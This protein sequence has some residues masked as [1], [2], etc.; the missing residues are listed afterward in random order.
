MAEASELV[1][2]LGITSDSIVSMSALVGVDEDGS[3]QRAITARA[4]HARDGTIEP[5]ANII[6]MRCGHVLE[7]SALKRLKNSMRPDAVVW[8]LWQKDKPNLSESDVR[9]GARDAGMSD[10]DVIDFSD[11][12]SALRLVIP[13][14]GS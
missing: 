3:I 10:Q 1:D 14:S 9:Q 12:Y 11:R 2:R 5:D 6:L 7:L 4:K 13:P 8:M